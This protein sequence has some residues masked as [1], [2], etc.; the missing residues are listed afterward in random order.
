MTNDEP[1]PPS[2]EQLANSIANDDDRWVLRYDSISG[3]VIKLLRV[4]GHSQ[5]RIARQLGVD[6]SAIQ[7]RKRRCFDRWRRMKSGASSP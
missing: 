4:F 2:M 7:R 1:L 3:D 6:R 5:E